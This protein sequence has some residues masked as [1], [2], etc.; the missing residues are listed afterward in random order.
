MG[1]LDTVKAAAVRVTDTV[2]RAVQSQAPAAAPPPSTPPVDVAPSHFDAAPATPKLPDLGGALLSAIDIQELKKGRTDETIGEELAARAPKTPEDVAKAVSELGYFDRDDVAHSLVKAMSDEQLKLLAQSP[3]G[4][5]LLN[6]AREELDA[7]WTTDAEKAQ[8]QRIDNALAAPAPAPAAA[9]K[10]NLPDALQP[11]KEIDSGNHIN[12]KV[13]GRLV[14]QFQTGANVTKVPDGELEAT[15]A[16][17]ATTRAA[18]D[19]FVEKMKAAGVSASTPPTLQQ[20]QEYFKKVAGRGTPAEVEK[21]KGELGAYLKNFYVHAGQGVDWGA[22]KNLAN[23]LEG[24]LA[25]Q[26][27]LDDRRTVIDCEG[28]AALTERL[29]GGIKEPGTQKPMFELMQGATPNHAI[30]GVFRAGRPYD[31]PFMVSND[32]V[33]TIPKDSVESARKLAGAK[34]S[35]EAV[36]KFLLKELVYDEV[37]GGRANRLKAIAEHRE[38]RPRLQTGR[39]FEARAAQR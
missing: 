34:S 13:D 8:M 31:A 28:Y 38:E 27:K 11:G 4:R 25:D 1:L 39:T 32:T 29:L 17:Q 5:T 15:P 7:G 3:E 24:A 33:T 35:D 14:R 19:A 12:Q 30:V 21:V 26:P 2:S 37:N 9:K 10:Q 18:Q 6:K 20:A 16:Q 36:Q 22:G 23:G